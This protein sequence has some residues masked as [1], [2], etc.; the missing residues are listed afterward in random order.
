MPTPTPDGGLPYE[1][2]T[3]T[4]AVLPA[5]AWLLT[6]AEYQSAVRSVIGADPDISALD[7]IPDNGVYP[8]MSSS[9]LVR[10]QQAE[11]YADLAE[12][13]TD[14]LTEQQLSTLSGCA[15][16]G[17][18]CKDGFLATIIPKAFRRPAT[19]EDLTSY[20]ELFDLAATSGDAALPFRS[21]LRG[22]LSSPYFL[23]RM[24]IG[25]PAD[26]ANPSFN[27]TN[28]EVATFLSFSVQ[29]GP[30]SAALLAAADRGDLTDPTKLG[31]EVD[32][33]LT[34]PGATEQLEHFLIQWL[35]L[36]P[37][38]DGVDKFEDVFP[39]FSAIKTSMFQEAESFLAA[40]G[41]LTGTL[42]TLLTAAIPDNQDALSAFYKSDPSGAGGTARAGLLS[43]GAV[44][45]LAAKKY[46]SSPTLRGLFVRDQLLC[47][48]ISLPENFTPPPIEA[49]ESTSSPTTTRQL[50]EL[51]TQ[52]PTC[53]GCHNLLDGVGFTFENFDGAGRFRT[54]EQ[55]KS[56]SF[57][58][59]APAQAINSDGSLLG[60]DVDG[61][62]SGAVALSQALSQSMW[63]RECVA[64]QAFRFY[65]GETETD[66]GA[67]PVIAGT[68]ALSGSG[69]LHDLLVA[70]LSSPS[71]VE[72]TRL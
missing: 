67:P 72:R 30:P 64:R 61:E 23:Y 44:M 29:G 60:T 15:A 9:G 43:L 71:T 7:P 39:G 62:Y 58:T 41:G 6:P 55:Y 42:E 5:R 45:S 35:R 3:P 18:S 46:L 63:V 59:P 16:L 49:T 24:E 48:H 52:D 4:A 56:P 1:P 53:S 66:R 51:H 32:R 14:A 40:N 17:A 38:E 22:L 31:A 12:S 68:S 33:L 19:A 70:L 11:Q 8:N 20:T 57:A 65:F 10:V 36:H 34:E 21:V 2:A 47:Q 25:A 28:H 69:T 50:Y 27:L 13:L 26:Q 37:F 54:T